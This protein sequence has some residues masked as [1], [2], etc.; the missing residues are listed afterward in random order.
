MKFYIGQRVKLK[1]TITDDS[2]LRFGITSLIEE[3]NSQKLTIS[4]ITKHSISNVDIYFCQF[5]RGRGCSTVSGKEIHGWWFREEMLENLG[6]LQGS[7]L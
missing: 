2:L 3:I 1:D 4:N 5:P 7:R 6:E